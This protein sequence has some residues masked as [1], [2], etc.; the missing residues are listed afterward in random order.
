[1]LFFCGLQSDQQNGSIGLFLRQHSLCTREICKCSFMST[2]TKMLFNPVQ[3]ELLTAFCF[4]FD[5]KHFENV[6]F[7]NW[8]CHYMYNVISQTV[9][10][11]LNTNPK[12]LVNIIGQKT[13]DAFSDWNLCKFSNPSSVVWMSLV[14]LWR[15]LKGTVIA[16]QSNGVKSDASSRCKNTVHSYLEFSKH[17][18]T[19]TSNLLDTCMGYNKEIN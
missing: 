4:H 8:W 18:S 6:A 10:S 13:F 15:K 14:D 9:F 5:R 16:D 7:R 19:F 1:M 11:L 17:C 3:F 2:V 12:G